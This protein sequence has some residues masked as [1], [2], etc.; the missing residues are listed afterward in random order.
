MNM[1]ML[2]MFADSTHLQALQES[3][4]ADMELQQ[5]LLETQGTVNAF[6]ANIGSNLRSNIIADTFMMFGDAF[7]SDFIK[8]FSVGVVFH[9][10]D[11]DKQTSM[12]LP[13]VFLMTD[14]KNVKAGL[15][16]NGDA[17]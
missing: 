13:F 5:V 9:N 14:A 16:Y 4:T 11:T 17:K 3:I 12:V 7:N 10:R 2:E 6:V 15:Y 1:T 8:Y